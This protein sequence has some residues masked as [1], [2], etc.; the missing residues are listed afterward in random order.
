MLWGASVDLHDKQ[1]E[2]GT[3]AVRMITKVSLLPS[4]KEAQWR[5]TADIN[6]GK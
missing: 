2:T 6:A 4:E 3:S 1:E 5:S